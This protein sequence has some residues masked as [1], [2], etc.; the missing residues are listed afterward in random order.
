MNNAYNIRLCE[1]GVNDTV[2]LPGAGNLNN[3]PYALVCTPFNRGNLY[4][5]DNNFQ[6]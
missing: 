4:A 5:F 6:F 2:G 3:I 1:H